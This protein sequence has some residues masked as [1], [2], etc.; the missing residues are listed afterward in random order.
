MILASTISKMDATGNIY[1]IFLQC[2]PMAGSKLSFC[3]NVDIVT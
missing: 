1:V 2:L 3:P